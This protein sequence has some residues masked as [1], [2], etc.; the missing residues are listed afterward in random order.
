[1]SGY[2]IWLRKVEKSV[3]SAMALFTAEPFVL[4]ERNE[5]VREAQFSN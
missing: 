5:E 2:I 4:R 1:M 3:I